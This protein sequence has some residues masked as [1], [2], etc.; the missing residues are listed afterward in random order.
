MITN[1]LIA[2]SH[3][4]FLGILQNILQSHQGLHIIGKATTTNDLLKTASVLKPDIIIADIALPGMKG[5]KTLR[6][7]ATIGHPVKIIFLWNRNHQAAISEAALAGCAGCMLQEANPT[8][9]HLA[10][11]QAIK[12]EVYYCD[13]TKRAINTRKNLQPGGDAAA[14]ML[15]EKYRMM[16]YCLWMGYRSKDMA[17][18]VKLTKETINTY[19]KKLRKIIGSLSL[20]AIESVLRDNGLI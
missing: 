14:A 16:L 6:K 8:E 5:F 3:Q 12:G 13:E 15:N 9:Y 20:S 18:G 19:R 7:L 1:L 10:I 11:R 2:H 17:T 4:V